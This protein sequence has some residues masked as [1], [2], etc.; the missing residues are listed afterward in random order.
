MTKAPKYHGL[1]LPRSVGGIAVVSV[2]QPRD[3]T[4]LM[5]AITST[6]VK[7]RPGRFFHST[8]TPFASTRSLAPRM[9]DPLPSS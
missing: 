7:Y 3:A 6:T 2:R 4:T 5:L 1:T 9:L 8:F